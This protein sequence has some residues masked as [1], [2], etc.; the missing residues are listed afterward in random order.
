MALWAQRLIIRWRD[1]R[2]TMGRPIILP[3]GAGA[4]VGEEAEMTRS[5]YIDGPQPQ[6]VQVQYPPTSLPAG[7]REPQSKS[8]YQ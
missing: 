4:M 8:R 2:L 5:V 1:M 6:T 3:K 7:M